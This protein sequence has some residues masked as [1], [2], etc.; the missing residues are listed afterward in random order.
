MIQVDT[1]GHPPIPF[2]PSPLVLLVFKFQH[3]L[4]FLA[5]FWVLNF[6]SCFEALNEVFLEKWEQHGFSTNVSH[7]KVLF[8]R[9]RFLTRYWA[10]QMKIICQSYV[11]RKLKYQFTQT[12]HTVLVLHLLVLGFLMVRVFHCF[13]I[14]KRP[15]SLI[16]TQFRGL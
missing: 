2:G 12:R 1:D 3:I 16:V 7:S 14:I 4:L 13:S 11:P 10:Y 6:R 15:S 5:I 8:L 9:D